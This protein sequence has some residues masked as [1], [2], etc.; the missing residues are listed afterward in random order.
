MTISAKNKIVLSI[1]ASL[2]VIILVMTII[3]YRSFSTSSYN[4][5]IRELDTTAQAVGK[6][7]KE[8]TNTYFTEVEY[9]S[10]MYHLAPT[11]DEAARL[12]YMLG[13]LD[14]LREQ[15]GIQDAYYCLKD[16]STYS[17]PAKGKVPNFNAKEKKREWYTR[18]FNGEKRIVTTPYV[19]SIGQ[20]V[21]AVAAPILSSG[22][23]QG[24]MCINLPMTE[25]T[26]FTRN[27]LNSSNIFLTRVDGYLLASENEKDLGKSLWEVIPDLQQ[28]KDAASMSRLKFSIGDEEYEGSVYAIDSLGWKV[29]TYENRK[30]IEADSIE[31]LMVT[32]GVAVAALILSAL[33]VS[34]LV[35]MLIFNPL[36]K[37]NEGLSRIEQGDLTYT[38]KGTIKDDELGRL[39]RT[40]ASMGQK[41]LSVVGEVRST[42]ISVSTGSQELSSTS[43]SLAQGATEQAASIE[44]VSSSMEQMVAN[45]GHN[46]EN[47]KETRN[48]SHKSALD[49]EQGGAAVA[50]TVSAMREIADKISVIEEIARQTNLLALNAAIEAARAGEHGKGFAVVA[51]EV[52][53]LA[54]R[55]GTAAAEISALSASSVAVA[56]EAGDMLDTMVPEIKHIAELIAEIAEASDEQNAGAETVNQAIHQLDQVIQQTAAASEEMSSTSQHLTSQAQ[57]LS[58]TVSF[59]KT[60]ESGAARQTGGARRDRAVPMITERALASAMD[61]EEFERF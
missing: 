34:L 53:K 17:I 1:F 19:S 37:V 36:E 48:I 24:V 52:R 45:I 16:G 2:A 42:V 4:N 50:K 61:T 40:L 46:A 26:E 14:Q 54:E 6:A 41:L 8:K 58:E 51:A 60:G 28:Y 57:H 35:R 39:M 32:A 18:I 29:W 5:H 59:F 27:V 43:E 3:S 9:A 44:E 25:I 30:V 23:V 49:A 56:E 12:E 47:A 13:M 22:Q 7:V 10:R 20:T 21:M 31:N 11:D 38:V 15:A 33:M 55:S